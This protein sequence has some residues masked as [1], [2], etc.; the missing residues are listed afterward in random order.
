[1]LSAVECCWSYRRL[2]ERFH[3]S[4]TTVLFIWLVAQNLWSLKKNLTLKGTFWRFKNCMLCHLRHIKGKDWCWCKIM[5]VLLSRVVRNCLEEVGIVTKVWPA[6][7]PDLNPIENFR[8]ILE[9]TSHQKRSLN[10]LEDVC[11]D[12][13]QFGKTWTKMT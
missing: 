3:V 13:S 4:H 12:W 7:S 5:P 9:R 1:M 2:G 11:R 10:T 6:R 8:D